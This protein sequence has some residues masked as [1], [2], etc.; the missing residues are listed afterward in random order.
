MLNLIEFQPV[1]FQNQILN[2]MLSLIKNIVY[3]AVKRETTDSAT[4][5]PVTFQKN[6]SVAG[7][8]L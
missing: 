5:F 4:N 8:F 3:V 2:K 1:Y 6:I 7:I